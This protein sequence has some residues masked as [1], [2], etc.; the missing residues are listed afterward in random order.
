[1]RRR[2]RFDRGTPCAISS[3]TPATCGRINGGR[4]GG[5]GREGGREGEGEEGGREGERWRERIE[6]EWGRRERV[7]ELQA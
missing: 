4:G 6:R 2:V 7:R 5:R 1:M 3:A